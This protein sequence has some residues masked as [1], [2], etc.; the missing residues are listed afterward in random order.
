MQNTK[1]IVNLTDT[2]LG[3]KSRVSQAIAAVVGT[4]FS[5]HCTKLAEAPGRHR[6]G[7]AVASLWEADCDCMPGARYI[8][9]A[10]VPKPTGPSPTESFSSCSVESTSGR[11]LLL[12]TMHALHCAVQV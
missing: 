11:S 1:A 8:I 4:E 5:R 2:K 9:R 6:R 3:T 7:S 10:L 12:H